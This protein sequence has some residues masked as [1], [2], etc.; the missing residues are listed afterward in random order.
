MAADNNLYPFASE[1]INEMEA[2]L[3][4]ARAA[5]DKTRFIILYD[6]SPKGDSCVMEVQPDPGPV[7]TTIISKPVADQSLIQ[8]H[9]RSTPATRSSPPSSRPGA[10][11]SPPRTTPS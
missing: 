1:D 11:S 7:N 3:A 8:H 9:T 5:G 6:G 10:R 4:V 2:G